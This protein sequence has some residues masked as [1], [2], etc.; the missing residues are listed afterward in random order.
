MR[1]SYS[2]NTTSTNKKMNFLNK[3]FSNCC[4]SIQ[5]SLMSTS[6]GF[7]P[8][9]GDWTAANLFSTISRLTSKTTQK[10]STK[11]TGIRSTWSSSRPLYLCFSTWRPNCPRIS[12]IC[13]DYTW[14]KSIRAKSLA[15][16]SSIEM[17]CCQRRSITSIQ[18]IFR[19]IGWGKLLNFEKIL[20]Q[21]STCRCREL[22]VVAIPTFT[23][24]L[25]K[26][27]TKKLR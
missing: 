16:A 1:I 2:L 11:T 7:T 9:F 20:C 3:T 10:R 25:T 27:L 17:V 6:Q 15:F 23:G 18:R 4:K 8:I 14:Y 26:R 24:E 13:K 5:H 12:L 21:I 19:M 22:V